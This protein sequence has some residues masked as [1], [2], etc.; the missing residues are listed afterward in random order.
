[1][2][3]AP[4]LKRRLE[5]DS[6]RLSDAQ[7]DRR[8]L[9]DACK[10]SR[11]LSDADHHHFKKKIIFLI[12]GTVKIKN[13]RAIGKNR[14]ILDRNVLV[15]DRFVY[16]KVIYINIYESFLDMVRNPAK[17]GT[18]DNDKASSICLNYLFTMFYWL[19]Y[20]DCCDGFVVGFETTKRVC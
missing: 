3:E 8:R 2:I 13:P 20:F 10:P 1:M 6:R 5:E 19:L 4:S 9:S 15:R 12:F 11:R 14:R 17:Y 16:I 18:S 7:E